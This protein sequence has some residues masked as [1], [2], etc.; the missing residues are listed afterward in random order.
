M[1][2]VIG[3]V[4]LGVL[5][6]GGIIWA[7]IAA[8]SDSGPVSNPNLSFNDANDPT[9]GPSDA[10]TVV[11]IFGDLQCP[12]CQAAEPGVTHIRQAYADSVK[13]IWDDF[14]LPP[15]LHPHA[16][17]AANAARCAEEQGKFW[18]MHDLMYQTQSTW[19]KSGNVGGDFLTMAGQLG[20]DQDGFQSCYGEKRFDSKV[21]DDMQEGTANGVDATPTFFVNNTKYVGVM[22][23]DQWDAI[24]KPLVANAKNT[25]S[26]PPTDTPAPVTAGS[27]TQE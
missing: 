1:P 20:L 26:A 13:I 21:A 2:F 5:L 10:K 4:A 15:T 9:L 8:P 12:A 3:I 22:S 19:E 23:A 25:V 17:E 6:V 16:R 14:P 7:V 11:R 18:E 27:S 24:L